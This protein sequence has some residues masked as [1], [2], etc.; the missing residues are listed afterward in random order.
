MDLSCTGLPRYSRWV[1][2][3]EESNHNSLFSLL[4]Q[5]ASPTNDL[6]MGAA[7]TMSCCVKSKLPS[8]FLSIQRSYFQHQGGPCRWQQAPNPLGPLPNPPQVGQMPLNELLW[9]CWA[10]ISWAAPLKGKWPIL[11]YFIASRPPFEEHCSM[12]SPLSG[13]SPA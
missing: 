11:F 3:N 12:T 4:P 8:C 5:E 6:N 9:N 10:V 2:Q 1:L 7:H 13:G